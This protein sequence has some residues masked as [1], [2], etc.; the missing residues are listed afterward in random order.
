MALC[1]A[2]AVLEG[3][4][5][6][7]LGVAAPRLVPELGLT[8]E[9]IGWVF[10]MSNLGLV[11]GSLAG[12]RMA[13]RLGRKRVL[14]GSVITFAVFTLAVAAVDGFAALLGARFLAGLGFG[15]SLPNMMALAAETSAPGR[16]AMTASM[17]FCGMPLGGGSVALLSQLIPPQYDWRALFV[18]GGLLPLLVAFAMQAWLVETLRPGSTPQS[19]AT[20]WSDVLFAAGRAVPTFCLWAAF[21]ATMLVLYLILNWLPLLVT[22]KGLDRAAAPQAAVAFNYASVVGA[23]V[24]GRWTDAVGPRWPLTLG[25]LGLVLALAGLADATGYGMVMVCS[26]AAGFCIL[27]AN[28]ALYGVAPG[29]YPAAVRGTGSGTAIGVGRTG[30]ILGPLVAGLML[31]GGA[32]VTTVILWMVPFAVLAAVAVFVLSFHRAPH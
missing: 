12:G 31:G 10:A 17:M 6:Q 7:A 2:I 30:S 28:Y 9:Q 16:R 8:P 5:I 3:F 29:F 20:R 13:D 15:A 18:V 32:D 1:F 26:A 22:Q 19:D 23:L 25:Y 14:Q 24:V 11:L 21:F 27:G 4:D